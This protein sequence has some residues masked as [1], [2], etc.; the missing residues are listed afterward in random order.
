[1]DLSL[2]FQHLVKLHMSAVHARERSR[3][4][5]IRGPD[6]HAL[7]NWALGYG[8]TKTEPAHVKLG[9]THLGGD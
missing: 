8:I 7:V 6:L 2:T 9:A 1:M 4:Q 3:H 5:G